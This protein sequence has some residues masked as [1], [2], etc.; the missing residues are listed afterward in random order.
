ME[1][2]S[3][4]SICKCIFSVYETI[5]I[6]ASHVF[7]P[8]YLDLYV[9]LIIYSYIYLSYIIDRS[10]SQNKFILFLLFSIPDKSM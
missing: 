7:T 10:V 1:G 6:V 3:H 8:D 4:F 2:S 5:D 9:C